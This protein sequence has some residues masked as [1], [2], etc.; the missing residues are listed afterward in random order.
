MNKLLFISLFL[1]FMVNL[2]ACK[3]K[4]QAD[5][6]VTNATIYTVDDSFSTAE[7]LAVKDGKILAT[8]STK[9]LE[10]RFDANNKIDATG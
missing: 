6:L 8:G 7:A 9:E 3:N 4:E 2:T 1:I 10:K 5:L